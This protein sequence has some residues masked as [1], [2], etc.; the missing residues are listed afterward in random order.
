MKQQIITGLKKKLLLVE[1]D[2]V[3]FQTWRDIYDTRPLIGK[4]TDIKEEQF[5]DF[6]YEMKDSSY[7]FERTTAKESFFSKLESLK[8]YFENKT[9]KPSVNESIGT[10]DLSLKLDAYYKA[11]SEVWDIN[12]CWLFELM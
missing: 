2:G 9:K 12:R 11:E 4:L 10:Y 3:L 5:A 7:P 6:S 8:I 1:R